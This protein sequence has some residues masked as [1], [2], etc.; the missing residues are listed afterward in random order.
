MS[1]GQADD[2]VRKEAKTTLGGVAKWKLLEQRVDAVRGE[3]PVVGWVLV[4]REEEVRRKEQKSLWCDTA[5]Q[6]CHRLPRIFYMFDG[7][8]QQR[9]SD[10]SIT[11]PKL[12]E[13]LQLVDSN[14]RVHVRTGECK[15]R[16][17]RANRGQVRLGRRAGGAEFDDRLR[18]RGGNDPA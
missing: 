7:V 18:R 15:A 6:L 5:T 17:D 1:T 13:I 11:K 4:D 9:R 12:A 16:E 10:G 3:P 14:A 2:R 8:Q